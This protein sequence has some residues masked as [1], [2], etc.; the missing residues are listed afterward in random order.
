LSNRAAFAQAGYKPSDSG[1]SH[2]AS[3]SKVKARVD[4]LI[5]ASA[6]KAGVTVD[7]IVAELAKIG[8][9]DIRRALDWGMTVPDA[10]GNSR[11]FVALKDSKDVD[12][13]TAATVS[14]VWQT[15]QGIRL[16]FHDKMA[17]LEVRI[18][19]DR[20]LEASRVPVH[21]GA[22]E[23]EILARSGSKMPRAHP[24]PCILT[25]VHDL[26]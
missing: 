19:G 15:N 2:L 16:K 22:S 5:S 17:A 8:F 10:D 3:S 13:D 12:D 1:A 9:S 4:E 11:Q 24:R 20:H 18:D 26:W 25:P 14:E 6:S 21:H 23:G 7:R